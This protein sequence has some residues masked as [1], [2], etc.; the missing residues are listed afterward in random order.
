[1]TL[2]VSLAPMRALTNILLLIAMAGCAHAP[3]KAPTPGKPIEITVTPDPVELTRED[4]H[5]WFR[6]EITVTLSAGNSREFELHR[7]TVG[8]AEDPDSVVI[9]DWDPRPVITA[10]QPYCLEVPLIRR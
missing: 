3:A 8:P 2:D 9:Y 6:G 4:N 7:M 1:M 5:Q 10:E